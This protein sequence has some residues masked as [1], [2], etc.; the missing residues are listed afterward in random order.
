MQLT[1]R[2]Q[3]ATDRQKKLGAH[4]YFKSYMTALI[5]EGSLALYQEQQVFLAE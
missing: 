4:P 3:A 2:K 1:R 5:H